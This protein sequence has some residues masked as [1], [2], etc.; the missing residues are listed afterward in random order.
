[1]KVYVT[2]ENSMRA[3]VTGV[4]TNKKIAEQE[5]IKRHDLSCIDAFE[6][7]GYNGDNFVYPLPEICKYFTPHMNTIRELIA[8][9]YNLEGCGCGGLAHIVVDDDNIDDDSIKWVLEYCDEEENKDCTERGLV[10]LICEELLKLNM[11]ERTL[12]FSGY[13]SDCFCDENCENCPI[14]HCNSS[15]A[16]L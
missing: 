5:R 15:E 1:M 8:C 7:K 13:Y 11:K 10:K 14:E 3:N 4:Y 12:L 9:L 16:K 6:L 2:Y